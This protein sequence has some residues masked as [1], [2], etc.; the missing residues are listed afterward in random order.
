MS[1]D[2]PHGFD[3][4]FAKITLVT[5]LAFS[6]VTVWP[7]PHDLDTWP[8]ANITKMYQFTK[9]ESC[10]K[11]VAARHIGTFLLLW[12]WTWPDDPERQ[13]WPKSSK[14]APAH[15]KWTFYFYNKN[16]KSYH[17]TNMTDISRRITTT[18]CGWWKL[19]IQP[20]L[21]AS[22]KK[23]FRTESQLTL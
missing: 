21:L 11:F 17:M 23:Y 22:W 18:L 5:C 15:Q 7:W 12:P 19:I 20:L 16:F 2:F 13:T 14:D 3:T 8:W 4:A 9:D 1:P 10:Q 6:V